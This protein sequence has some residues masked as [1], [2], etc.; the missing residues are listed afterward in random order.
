ML[1]TAV[2]SSSAQ[3]E[4]GRFL[5]TP[6]T[7]SIPSDVAELVHQW[8]SAV[9]NIDASRFNMLLREVCPD[10][11]DWVDIRKERDVDSYLKIVSKRD[12][13]NTI[14]FLG[15]LHY[16]LRARINAE[17]PEAAISAAKLLLV[18]FEVFGRIFTLYRQGFTKA[19]DTYDMMLIYGLL[20]LVLLTIYR[21]FDK[22]DFLNAGLKVNDLL[23]T[24][25]PYITTPTE[26]SAALASLCYGKSLVE[27]F[28]D[29]RGF[30]LPPS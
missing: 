13:V 8:P 10:C 12:A 15:M 18:K 22:L 17:V 7:D 20:S 26:T 11:T 27:R 21:D 16:Q 30:R 28:Y 5:L 4:M 3:I 6:Y 19:C 24:A 23:V 29:S 14:Q 25:A 2:D 1:S 9:K